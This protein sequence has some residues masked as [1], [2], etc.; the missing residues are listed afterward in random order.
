MSIEVEGKKHTGQLGNFFFPQISGS[1]AKAS[2]FIQSDKT[3]FPDL[4][5]FDHPQYTTPIQLNQSLNFTKEIGFLVGFCRRQNLQQNLAIQPNLASLD[6][7][8]QFTA[9]TDL[10]G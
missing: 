5:L 3:G 2:C 4:P 10:R 9:S 1:G 8:P 6:P 7:D